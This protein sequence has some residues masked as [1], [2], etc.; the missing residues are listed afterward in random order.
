MD[1][2]EPA[3]LRLNRTAHGLLLGTAIFAGLLALA[4][5]RARADFPTTASDGLFVGVRMEPGAGLLFGYDLDIYLTGDRMFSLGPAAMVT[6]LDSEGADQGRRQDFMV[7]VDALRFKLALNNGQGELRPFLFVGGGFYYA[8]LPQQQSGLMPV[9]LA[10]GSP[11]SARRVFA[12]LEDFG[13][14]VSFGGGFDYYFADS[15]GL[16]LGY[17]IHVRVTEQ[18]RVPRFWSELAAGIRFGL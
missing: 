2:K 15:W 3:L 16:T 1:R 9:T 7:T 8:S 12:A 14:H 17:A 6:V 4:P 18:E 10:D 5:E 11:S 13:G